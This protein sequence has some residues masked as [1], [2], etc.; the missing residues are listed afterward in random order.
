MA[1]EKRPTYLWVIGHPRIPNRAYVLADNWELATV[2][3]AEY[4]GVP[5]S[6]IAADCYEI[7]HH[8]AMRNICIRCG[9]VYF[10]EPPFCDR[11]IEKAKADRNAARRVAGKY[12]KQQSGRSGA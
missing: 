8:K 3:A 6:K 11:C 9:N 7:N 4:W 5:W 2:A 1:A 10:G 12:W